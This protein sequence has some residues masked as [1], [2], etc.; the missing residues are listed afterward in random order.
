MGAK[1]HKLSA[2]DIKEMLIYKIIIFFSTFVN[3]K[4]VY[5]DAFVIC[6]GLRHSDLVCRLVGN[7]Y[8]S[9]IFISHK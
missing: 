7:I 5:V 4:I 3:W 6:L 9:E 2:I 8:V 1:C